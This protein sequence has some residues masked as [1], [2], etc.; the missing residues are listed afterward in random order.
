MAIDVRVNFSQYDGLGQPFGVEGVLKAMQKY[1]IEAAVLIPRLAVDSN[2]RLG[3]KELFDAVKAD[4]RLFAYFAVNPNYP[5]ECIELMRS[6]MS[7]PKIVAAA[8]FRGS[9]RD[10]PN[11]DDYREI[12]NAYRRF[13]RPVLVDAASGE[14]IAAAAQM[15]REFPTIKFIF[16]SMGGADWKRAMT[17]DQ[18]LN[19]MLETSGSF[20]CEKI[21]EAVDRFGAH[22]ILFGSDMPFSDPAS[23]LALVQSSG[24]PKDAMSKILGEN[25]KRLFKL[26]TRA[27]QEEQAT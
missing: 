17:C 10:Y 4:K 11:P 6:A 13:T 14:A 27:T 26:G 2:F 3:N 1:G 7:S 20:D 12:L 16:G 23:M 19:V 25:A 22:R 24:V 18:L 5:E 15:A 21:E 8:L 9:S